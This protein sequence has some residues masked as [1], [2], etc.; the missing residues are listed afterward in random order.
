MSS[1]LNR[2]NA[3]TWK[4]Q[5]TPFMTFYWLLT[6]LRCSGWWKP[7]KAEKR[8][9]LPS[10]KGDIYCTHLYTSNEILTWLLIYVVA[11]CSAGKVALSKRALKIGCSFWTANPSSHVSLK[12]WVNR[13]ILTNPCSIIAQDTALL[14]K[15]F[16]LLNSWDFSK[17]PGVATIERFKERLQRYWAKRAWIVRKAGSFTVIALSTIYTSSWQYVHIVERLRERNRFKFGGL[18]GRSCCSTVLWGEAM[19]QVPTLG[20]ALL[21]PFDHSGGVGS[22]HAAAVNGR[23]QWWSMYLLPDLSVLVCSKMPKKVLDCWHFQCLGH[24]GI[25]IFFASC[26]VG[27]TS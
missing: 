27:G 21:P 24:H 7:L 12:M 5:Q 19:L 6:E 22:G 11:V 2:L 18:V 16:S 23:G 15:A 25:A 8:P 20:A 13:V 26:I 1:I 3:V 10:E 14:E 17:S 4:D 9:N